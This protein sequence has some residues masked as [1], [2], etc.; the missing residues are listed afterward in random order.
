MSTDAPAPR[1]KSAKLLYKPFG[2]ANSVVGGL[3]ANAIFGVVWK[4]VMHD[5]ERP[6]A[7]DQQRDLGEVLAG[8]A[9]QGLVFAV[10]KAAIDRGG[11]KLFARWTGEWPG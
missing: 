5:T 6:S 10:T 2:V 9:L 3:V 8:A 1:S 7:T 4:R 11:A